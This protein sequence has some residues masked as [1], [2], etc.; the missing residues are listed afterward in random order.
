VTPGGG[1][2]GA[3]CRDKRLAAGVRGQGAAGCR[4]PCWPRPSVGPHLSLEVS[5]RPQQLL[6]GGQL[7]RGAS[8][9]GGAGSGVPFVLLRPWTLPAAN[10]KAAS[11]GRPQQARRRARAAAFPPP[12]RAGRTCASGPGP[13]RRAMSGSTCRSVRTAAAACGGAPSLRASSAAA[14][15]H[16]TTRRLY[17]ERA[18]GGE[19]GGRMKEGGRSSGGG[20][21]RPALM[22]RAGPA[23][24]RRARAPQ[25]PPGGPT[26][27]PPSRPCVT[28]RGSWQRQRRRPAAARRVPR[29]AGQTQ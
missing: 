4:C 28:P 17:L 5:P 8:V 6:H 11:P 24:S 18:T 19:R 3:L 13:K 15:Q 7:R 26:A 20:L 23:T 21:G 27:G 1:G 29:A 22:Q 12:P 9:E 16:S 25:A 2:G 10:S 14:R